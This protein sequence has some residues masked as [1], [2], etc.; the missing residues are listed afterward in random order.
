MIM[1][2]AEQK[3]TTMEIDLREFDKDTLVRFIVYSHANDLTFNEALVKLLT[4]NLPQLQKED[5]N[6]MPLL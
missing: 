6:Q 3:M 2:N 5:E 1:N 4:D